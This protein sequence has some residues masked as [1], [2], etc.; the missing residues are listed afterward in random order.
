MGKKKQIRISQCMIVK[1]EEK[2]IER[3]LIWGK[4]IM[5]EQI[6]VDT[7]SADNTVELAK[8]MGAKVLHFQWIDDFAA[9][10]NYAIEQAK[11]DWIALLDADEYMD[12]ED[13]KKMY[14]GLSNIIDDSFD[15]VGTGWQQIDDQGEIS[16]SGTQVRFFRNQPDIRYRRRIHEQL[17]SL[18]GRELRIA[19]VSEQISIFHTGYQRNELHDKKKSN[20][21]QV[22]ILKEL[23]EDPK[24]YEMMGYMGDECLGDGKNNEAK[25]WYS[26]AVDAMPSKLPV[27]DQRSAVTFIRLLQIMTEIEKSSWEDVEPV[28]NRAV[29][30]LPQEADFDYLIGQYFAD[31]G[32]IKQAASYLEAGLN[33]LNTYGCYNKAMFLGADVSNVYR[34]L[35]RCFYELGEFEKCLTYGVGYLKIDKY[36]M[37]V[38][39]RILKVLLPDVEKAAVNYQDVMDFLFKIYDFGSLKDRLFL[40][41]TAEKSDCQEFARYGL[42]SLFTTE[43]RRRLRLEEREVEKH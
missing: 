23:E 11:G 32:N 1:N 43:E 40:I 6:V 30:L 4:N 10:K 42:S 9:A 37:G 14:F 20:R 5:W 15:G 27:N 3:A 35:T 21:N 8:K 13:A 12:P 34:V 19:D 33:K 18:T 39:A 2:N 24:S 17:Y 36:E 16:L 31:Q 29:K 7:G 22:L 38:L 25:S 28:Y 41:K 26:R